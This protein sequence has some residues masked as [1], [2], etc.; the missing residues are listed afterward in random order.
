MKDEKLK[1]RS[2]DLP[3]DRVP[4]TL[5][6]STKPKLKSKRFW[7][8]VVMGLGALITALGG[9]D[10]PGPGFL[11][12]GLQVEDAGPVMGFLGYL[13]MKYGQFKADRPIK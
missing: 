9:G 3:K 10:A 13:W 8:W 1:P 7:G 6:A 12:D 2:V 4:I 11:G 5:H